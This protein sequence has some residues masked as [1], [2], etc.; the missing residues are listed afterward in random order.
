[1]CR[2]Q[3]VGR[4]GWSCSHKECERV[5]SREGGRPVTKYSEGEVLGP[6]YL[7]GRRQEGGWRGT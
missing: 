4:G 2:T 7:G 6:V 5:T 1:M 3:V